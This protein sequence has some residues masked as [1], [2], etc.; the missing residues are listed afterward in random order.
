MVHS[1]CCGNSAAKPSAGIARV[2]HL[3]PLLALPAL[4]LTACLQETVPQ[5][6][7]PYRLRLVPS[8]SLP[9]AEVRHADLF[10]YDAETG[11]LDTWQSWDGNGD[12]VL[13]C[14]SAKRERLAVAIANLPEREY[15]LDQIR[16]LDDLPTLRC[17][18]AEEVPGLPV[19]TGQVRVGDGYDESADLLLTPLLSRIR[20]RSLTTDFSGRAY[21]GASLENVRVFLVNAGSET[22]LFP[23]HEDFPSGYA[24]LSE[25]C[26]AG[27]LPHP[28]LLSAAVTSRLGPGEA[29]SGPDLFCYPNPATEEGPGSPLTRLVIQADLLGETWYYPMTLPQ[30][31]SNVSYDFDVTLTQTG[32]RNPDEPVD[33]A[34]AKVRLSVV[35]WDEKEKETIP[36]RLRLQAPRSV[37][38]GDEERITD[39]NLFVF[40]AS[41]Q[42]HEQHW[43]SAREWSADRDI[44]LRLLSPLT[45]TLVACANIGYRLPAVSSLEELADYRYYLVYPDEYSKGMPMTGRLDFTAGSA[46]EAVIPLERMLAKLTLQ[47]DRSR[48]S[49]DIRFDIRS[50]EIGNCPKSARLL[51]GSRAETER[52]L[53]AKGFY[54]EGTA[55]DPL[56]LRTASGLSET[57]DLYLLENL[58]GTLL[59]GVTDSRSKVLPDGHPGKN[60]CSY[61]EMHIDY[62]SD[63]WDS[64]YDHYLIYR[65]YP[66][67][68]PADFNIRRD[69][70][71]T[72]VI[73]PEGDGLNDSPWRIDKTGLT[74]RR[75]FDLHPAAYNE[76]SSGESFHIWCDVSPASTPFTIEAVGH[77][78]DPDVAALYDYTVDTDGHGLTIHPRK[79]GSALFYFSAGYP[80]NRDTLALLVIDP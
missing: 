7:S 71:Y 17:S 26:D 15:R 52:D 19:M 36:F 48:L 5:L 3:L 51:G 70:H 21:E 77:D 31:A 39:V 66:G 58:Q 78:D 60:V 6:P 79:G 75:R 74:A 30:P 29:V 61:V 37:D 56:N 67:D 41:G 8:A 27:L 4:S 34:V 20:L 62:Q 24:N 25:D 46:D 50:V 18:L 65:F 69:T 47:L 9:S 49:K 43:W 12:A 80:I 57:I 16:T 35:G 33:A 2:C 45:Y 59:E 76:C 44:P 22:R 63:D 11:V 42:L 14:S 53:F 32:S 68:G 28:E 73:T 72:Y 10:I 40:T 23:E 54:K 64:D 38:P 13:T 1:A 55:V